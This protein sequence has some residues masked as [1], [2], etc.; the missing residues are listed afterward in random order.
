[1]KEGYSACQSDVVKRGQGQC[2]DAK[3]QSDGQ[4]DVVGISVASEWW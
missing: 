2:D 1:M 3:G 4:S